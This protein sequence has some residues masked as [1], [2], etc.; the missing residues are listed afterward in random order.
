MGEEMLDLRGVPKDE[1]YRSLLVHCSVVLSGID[2]HIAKMST[3]SCLVHHSFGFLWTG[4][5]RAVIP[6]KL[7]RVGPYQGTLGCLEIAFG[8]GVCGTAAATGRTQVVSD[9]SRF[10]GH[11]SCDE[12]S[13]SEIVVPVKDASGKLLAIFDIDSAELGTFDDADQV[14][15]ET[16]LAKFFSAS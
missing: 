8:R 3:I 7:L 9:V 2:D 16:L 12:R 11:I 1:A 14:G 4:F 10:P 5:Y 6:G 13:R 15:L